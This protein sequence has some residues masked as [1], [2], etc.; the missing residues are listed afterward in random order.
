MD[1]SLLNP[2]EVAVA[3]DSRFSDLQLK[4]GDRMQ[5]QPPKQ[6]TDERCM[7]RLIGYVE[8]LSVLVTSPF[9]GG[10]RLQLFEGEE[11]VVRAFTGRD[12][13]GFATEVVKSVKHP[14]EYLHLAYP[15]TIQALQVRKAV[16]V[17]TDIIASVSAYNRDDMEPVSAIVADVSSSGALIATGEAIGEVGDLLRIVFRV[18]LHGVDSDLT[19]DAFVRNRYADYLPCG[20]VATVH[21][22][23]E[24]SALAPTDA[25][26]LESLIYQELVES[27]RARVSAG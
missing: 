25:M 10:Q 16:R 6:A 7:V 14:F 9:Q 13:F 11:L 23:V 27:P 22:G 8:G 20:G 18:R 21:H 19:V 24:F 17:A 2:G 4:V 5:L 3:E 1:D 12:A 15:T 26:I